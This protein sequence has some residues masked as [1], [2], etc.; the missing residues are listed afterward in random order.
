MASKHYRARK[1]AAGAAAPA[2]PVE[3]GEGCRVEAA[4]ADGL[5]EPAAWWRGLADNDAVWRGPMAVATAE[6]LASLD[7]RVCEMD[8]RLFVCEVRGGNSAARLSGLR[9]EMLERMGDEARKARQLAVLLDLAVVAVFL[10][11]LAASVA[12]R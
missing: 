12:A 6:D 3:T 4:P 10:V 2:K 5:E 1:A 9:D 7:A 8:R 11:F